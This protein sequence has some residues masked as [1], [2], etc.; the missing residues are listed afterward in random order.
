MRCRKAANPR[1]PRVL[2]MSATAGLKQTARA[3]WPRPA[4][5]HP[6]SGS[7]ASQEKL[8]GGCSRKP[9][10]RIAPAGH[11]HHTHELLKRICD[12]LLAASRR[13]ANLL[14]LLSPALALRIE[15][16]EWSEAAAAASRTPEGATSLPRSK[17]AS[18]SPPQFAYRVARETRCRLRLPSGGF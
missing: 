5:L 17:A 3:G 16:A 10:P 14:Y 13:P 2:I 7:A 9:R 12:P 1:T 11:L 15:Y 6:S 8:E 4:N 18:F